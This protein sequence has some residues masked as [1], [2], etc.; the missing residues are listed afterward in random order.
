MN[1]K[2]KPFTF[3]LENKTRKQLQD[4]ATKE[5]TSLGKIVNKIITLFLKSK[6]AIN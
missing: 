6:S 2:K 3:V 4:I 1:A 5:D